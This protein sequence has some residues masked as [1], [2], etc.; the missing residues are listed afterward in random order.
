[1]VSGRLLKAALPML[2]ALLLFAC[3]ASK[4]IES[5]PSSGISASP[6]YADQISVAADTPSPSPSRSPSHTPS[7][8]PSPSVTA[9]PAASAAIFSAGPIARADGS[10]Y[11]AA[12]GFR[13]DVEVLV[14]LQGGYITQISVLSY[15]DDERL[16]DRAKSALIARVLSAQ[17]VDVDV[18][19]GATH[20]SDGILGAV[21]NALG[22]SYTE[23]A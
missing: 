14:T 18:V 10:Y 16:F 12:A 2:F 4:P 23:I 8:T 19:A 21:A 22:F 3:A 5:P 7:L 15:V 9:T 1:M 6:V 13:G 17:G 11:G 20:S